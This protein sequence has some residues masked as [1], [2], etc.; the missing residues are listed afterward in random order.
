MAEE[1]TKEWYREVEGLRKIFRR[2]GILHLAKKSLSELKEMVRSEKPLPRCFGSG[3]DRMKMERTGACKQCE[4]KRRQI[5]DKDHFCS[6]A[7]NGFWDGSRPIGMYGYSL[8]ECC[9]NIAWLIYFG[10]HPK[11]GRPRLD[12]REA[13]LSGRPGRSKAE[14]VQY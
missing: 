3:P 9:I 5:F 14:L 10:F 1:G 12:E 7:A 4:P 6:G 13:Q 11:Y 2:E 8:R